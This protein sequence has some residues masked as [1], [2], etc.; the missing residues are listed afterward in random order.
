M[1]G[2]NYNLHVWTHC[3]LR[4][5]LNIPVTQANWEIIK[6]IVFLSNPQHLW[7][8]VATDTVLIRPARRWTGVIILY[9]LMGTSRGVDNVCTGWAD[10]YYRGW[11]NAYIR[12][13][14]HIITGP[15]MVWAEVTRSRNHPPK[16]LS[17][18]QQSANSCMQHYARNH[19]WFAT[20]KHLLSQNV[21]SPSFNLNCSN[22]FMERSVKSISLYAQ[23]CPITVEKYLKAEHSLNR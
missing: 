12:P 7:L 13:R 6:A 1:T 14:W 3:Q 15:S 10:C 4:T 5:L 21:E 16:S 22:W 9:V 23:K 18:F 17:C 11:G 8:L 2:A 19:D 20:C